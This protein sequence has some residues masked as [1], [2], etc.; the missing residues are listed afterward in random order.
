MTDPTEYEAPGGGPPGGGPAAASVASPTEEEPQGPGPAGTRGDTT[1]L[2]GA[3]RHRFRLRDARPSDDPVRAAVYWVQDDAGERH[4][5]KWYERGHATGPRVREALLGT[6]LPHALRLTEAGEIGGHPYEIA[7]S[8]GDTDLAQYR[9]GFP[10]PAPGALVR[11]VVAQLHAALAAVHERG[12]VH[13]DISPANVVLGSLDPAD[14]DLTLIDFSIARHRLDRP[15]RHEPWQGTARYMSPQAAAMDQSM[16][17]ADDWW[18]LGML[19]AELAGGRHPIRHDDRRYVLRA[20]TSGEDPDL[21]AVADPRVLHLCRGLLTHRPDRRWGASEVAEWLAGGTPPVHAD[22]RPAAAPGGPGG[23]PGGG[24]RGFVFLGRAH[25]DPVDLGLACADH[26][27]QF[28]ATLAR[29]GRRAE[30]T[31]WLRQFATAPEVDAARREELPRLLAALE[32]APDVVMLVRLLTWLAP[33]LPPVFRDAD[34][35]PS[36]GLPALAR[37]AEGGDARAAALVRELSEHAVL[38]L[39]NARPGG[40][41][42]ALADRRW[43]AALD[44]WRHEV[45]TLRGLFP[46]LRA[47]LR[48]RPEAVVLDDRAVAALLHLAADP[49]RCRARLD[50]RLSSVER[51]LPAPVD[52]FEWL[53]RDRRHALRLLLADRLAP[54]AEDAAYRADAARRQREAEARVTALGWWLQRAVD[55]QRLP[56]ALGWAAAGAAGVTFPWL[57]VIGAADVAGLAPQGAVVTAWGLAIPAA[58]AVLAMELW[59]AVRVGGSAYH[60]GFSLAEAVITG[61]ERIARPARRHRTLAA[62]ALSAAVFVLFLAMTVAPWS[63]PAA[64]VIAV[65]WWTWRR[66][67][68]WRSDLVTRWLDRRAPNAPNAL[69]AG[70]APSGDA[71]GPPGGGRRGPGPDGAGAPGEREEGDTD[72]PG[73]AGGGASPGDAGAAGA[74]PGARGGVSPAAADDGGAGAGG[75]A[76]PPGPGSGTGEGGGS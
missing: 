69:G 32:R 27:P 64:T 2:P 66:H 76:A 4:V 35:H 56:S 46:P 42:L 54:L 18:S 11:S 41:G 7:P 20:V 48:D 19:V 5:V 60:P 44:A 38:P 6:P 36:T 55:A 67:W 74:G 3:L 28:A 12:L 59:I 34:L 14:P 53:V 13:R 30:F 26:W 33:Q 16:E 1:R 43:R 61:A 68:A 23:G 75:R 51:Q 21:S 24:A 10:G 52:W 15:G 22:V 73:T 39:L 8:F 58:A 45:D 57:L 37:L 65:G 40:D 29:R 70:G 63:W 49:D 50:A 62:A 25:T 31:R 72:V 71:A 47:T 17:P 9:R